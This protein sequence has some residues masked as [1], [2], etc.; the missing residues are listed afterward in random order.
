MLTPQTLVLLSAHANPISLNY[1]VMSDR[2]CYPCLV[3]MY[4][5]KYIIISIRIFYE[6][7]N[8]KKCKKF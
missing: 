4:V 1:T 6:N 3:F 5:D 8:T 7:K 2:Y